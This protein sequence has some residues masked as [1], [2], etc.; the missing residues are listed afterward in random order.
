MSDLYEKLSNLSSLYNNNELAKSYGLS[1]QKISWE[2]SARTT[3]SCWGPNISDMTLSA[4]DPKTRQSYQMNMIRKPNFADITCDLPIEHFNV[5][6]GNEDPSKPITSIPLSEYIK[7]I[8]DYNTFDGNKPVLLDERD[9]TILCSAQCCLLPGDEKE[10]EF[11]VNMYNYQNSVLVI[12]SS[13][14]GTS[15]HILSGKQALYFNKTGYKHSF[16][17]KRLKIERKEKNIAIE[18]EMNEDEQDR[19]TIIIY[20][21]PLVGPP[22]PRKYRGGNIKYNIKNNYTDCAAFNY[23]MVES[24]KFQV[25][26]DGCD[27]KDTTLGIDNAMLSVSNQTYGEFKPLTFGILQRDR[28]FPIRATYQFYKISDTN[29]LNEEDIS[30]ISQKIDDIYKLAKTKGSLVLGDTSKR[31]TPSVAN[32]ENVTFSQPI[33]NKLPLFRSGKI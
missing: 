25:L 20:Q 3:G 10:T 27:T 21:I 2:D 11:D 19:N 14:Q 23:E 28:R 17:A 7:N 18:G 16:L 26:S 9:S 32:L 22:R 13:S 31:P 15:S 8:T 12:I 4:I 30:H 33:I 1:I 24:G 6:V 5:T 29:I